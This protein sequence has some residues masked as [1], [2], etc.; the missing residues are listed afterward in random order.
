M[1]K[2]RNFKLAIYCTAQSMEKIT[3]EALE[4]QLAFFQKY[5]GCDKVYLEPYRDGLMIPDE[6]LEMLKAFFPRQRH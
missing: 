2:Y 4:E 5:S 1:G 3:E 6:Q